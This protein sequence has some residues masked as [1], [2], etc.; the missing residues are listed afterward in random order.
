MMDSLNGG[1]TVEQLRI[2]RAHQYK[3]TV[4]RG[5]LSAEWK[6]LFLLRRG[7]RPPGQAAWCKQCVVL[8]RPVCG[9]IAA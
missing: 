7:T 8:N 9:A 2:V 3:T 1:W 6:F 5:S 4:M